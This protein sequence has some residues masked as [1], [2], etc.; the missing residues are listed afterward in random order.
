MT[1]FELDDVD[2]V[3]AEDAA[4][5]AFKAE[6]ADEADR[7]VEAQVAQSRLGIIERE[8]PEELRRR[9]DMMFKRY[10]QCWLEVP[11]GMIFDEVV[12][13][14]FP[15]SDLTAAEEVHTAFRDRL[16]YEEATKTWYLWNGIFHERIPGDQLGHWLTIIL[17]KT[18]RERLK[19]VKR[20]YKGQADSMGGDAAKRRMADYTKDFKEHRNYRDRVFNRGGISLLMAEIRAQFAVSSDHFENDRRWLVFHNGVLDL[21]ELRS[22]PPVPGDLQSI[23]LLPHSADRPVWRCVETSFD[24][25]AFSAAWQVFLES[26]LPDAQARKFLAVSVGAAMLGESKTKTIP[27]LTGPR[28]SG[29][30]VF[31]DSIHKLMGGYGGQPDT[32]A[33]NKGNG[34]NFEQD[35]FRGLR[36]AGV[37]EPD[38]DRKIDDSFLKKFTGGDILSTRNL[39]AKS[40]EWKSQGMLFIASNKD[41]KFNSGDQAILSRLATVRFPN[42]FYR[43]GT[44]PAGKEE[45]IIDLTLEER[46]YGELSGVLSW[47]LNGMLVYL[48]EGILIPDSVELHRQQQYIEGSSV[49]MWF[50]DHVA[51]GESEY[52]LDP[53]GVIR[54]TNSVYADISGVYMAYA[55]WCTNFLGETAISKR[56]FSVEVQEY[57][58][59]PLVKS[60]TMRVPRLIPRDVYASIS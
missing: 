36:F 9:L 10:S 12:A 1:D 17:S 59:L 14:R 46:I 40:V 49:I 2:S 38:T 54:E 43:L 5:E 24:P 23:R 13:D 57:L 53:V 26:S 51:T 39:N 52:V 7:I 47:C 60:S 28:D 55:Y 18:Y 48:S 56:K 8:T 25:N 42:R 20:F 3:S 16:H 30:T 11:Q 27:V 4:W 44:A 45:Y 37:S 6:A 32:S 35:R 34:T 33:I 29:K 21:E 19:E 15:A 58:G 41:L 31:I 50:I 22:N